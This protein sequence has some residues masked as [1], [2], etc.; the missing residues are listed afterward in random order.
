M[1]PPLQR[2]DIRVVMDMAN[3]LHRMEASS[4]LPLLLTAPFARRD[5]RDMRDL[6]VAYP[7][8]PTSTADSSIRRSPL[9]KAGVLLVATPPARRSEGGTAG[10]PRRCPLMS[11][12]SSMASQVRSVYVEHGRGH[13]PGHWGND[14]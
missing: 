5:T 8:R 9:T 6:P 2:F 10:E 14:C 1:K 12:G 3:L 11:T 4:A 7:G 13:D